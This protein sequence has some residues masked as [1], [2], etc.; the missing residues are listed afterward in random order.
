[1]T[2]LSGT[3]I[4]N[5]VV[6]YLFQNITTNNLQSFNEMCV[7]DQLKLQ[8]QN[9]ILYRQTVVLI[10]EAL[11]KTRKTADSSYFWWC[12]IPHWH[13]S[14]HLMLLWQMDVCGQCPKQH[15]QGPGVPHHLNWG[16]SPS[17]P[18]SVHS[19]QISHS[20]PAHTCQA[21]ENYPDKAVYPFISLA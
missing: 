15:G 11:W 1:M 5:H 8:K 3:K 12:L 17:C 16:A 18:S 20:S 10:E 6:I 4:S 7:R 14:A 2:D 9:K 13:S 19:P 21:A